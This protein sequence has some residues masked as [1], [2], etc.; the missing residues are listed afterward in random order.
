[1]NETESV[2][3]EL[4][5]ISEFDNMAMMAAEAFT[6]YEPISSA[7][8]ISS[9]DFADF[10][11]LLEPKLVREQLTVIARNQETQ[12]IIGAMISDDFAIEPP[13]EILHLSDN[14]EPVWSV[15]D[16]LD[17]QRLGR[18]LPE[19]EYLHFFLLAVDHR[20]TGRKIA[21]NLVRTCMENGVG[22]GYKTGVVEASGVVSQHIFRKLGFVDRFEIL[23]KTFMFQ[24]N[25]IF[26]SIEEQH[27]II[28]MD[29]A[30]AQ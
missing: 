30:L 18:I 15:L 16:E 14:F 27:G 26:D 28:L 2:Q 9:E 11:R 20:Q 6:R 10:I 13:K 1:M 19:G 23:Y 5:D 29:K 24:G 17:S 7:L 8:N 3:Y 12:Q 25:R 22:K 4:V 21:K